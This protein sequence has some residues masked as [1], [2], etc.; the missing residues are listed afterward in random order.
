MLKDPISRGRKQ[1]KA[2]LEDGSSGSEGHQESQRQ[3]IPLKKGGRF[4]AL[5]HESVPKRPRRGSE[6]AHD[7][8]PYHHLREK[9]HRDSLDL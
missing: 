5:G 7:G 2:E 9:K 6:K 1:S 8:L 4:D 3:G